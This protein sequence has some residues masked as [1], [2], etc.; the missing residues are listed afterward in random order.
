MFQSTAVLNARVFMN[1]HLNIHDALNS[2]GTSKF[3]PHSSSVRN[4]PCVIA[5]GPSIEVSLLHYL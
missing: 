1:I 4:C 5:I 3:S 2:N